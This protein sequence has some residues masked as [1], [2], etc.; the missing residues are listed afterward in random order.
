MDTTKLLELK[1]AGPKDRARISEVTSNFVIL[2]E[3]AESWNGFSNTGT[4]KAD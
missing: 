2:D 3:L 1:V 4:V